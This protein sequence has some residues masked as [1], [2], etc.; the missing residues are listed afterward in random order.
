M[1]KDTKYQDL[2]IT[3]KTTH[4]YELIFSKDG[5]A[6]PITGW[7][8]YL[9]VKTFINDTDDNAILKKDITTHNDP[10]NGITTINLSAEDTNL[11]TKNY[12]YDIRYK[13]T[14]NNEGVIAHGRMR[15]SEAVTKRA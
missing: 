2:L 1:D 13:D 9:T 7:T 3:Q 5:T 11:P 6:E 4:A 8:I 15:I 14:N 12:W 10:T